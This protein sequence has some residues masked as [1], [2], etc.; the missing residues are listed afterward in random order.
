M[1]GYLYS[2]QM[3]QA[4]NSG[5]ETHVEMLNWTSLVG[6]C[7]VAFFWDTLLQGPCIYI[8][9]LAEYLLT[10]WVVA[11]DAIA[12]KNNERKREVKE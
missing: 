10:N 7:Y 2:A 3:E 6:N 9:F 12:S 1:P 5:C 4:Q 11:G 8:D